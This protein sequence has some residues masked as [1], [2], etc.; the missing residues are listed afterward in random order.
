M[1]IEMQEY[2]QGIMFEQKI[3]TLKKNPLKM[4]RMDRKRE[5]TPIKPPCNDT[6]EIRA[7]T[8]SAKKVPQKK[9]SQEAE[10]SVNN[11]KDS[12]DFSTINE[13]AASDDPFFAP[14]TTDPFGF[15][16]KNNAKKPSVISRNSSY[17][18]VVSAPKDFFSKEQT[19]RR[20]TTDN[21]ATIDSTL[22]TIT[23]STPKKNST[24]NGLE[25]LVKERK[26][27][28]FAVDEDKASTVVESTIQLPADYPDGNY[29]I[30]EI[31]CDETSQGTR[32][33]HPEFDTK[34]I[35]TSETAQDILATSS[36]SRKHAIEVKEFDAFFPGD[37]GAEKSK[38]EKFDEFF[39]P[40]IG[41]DSFF[42]DFAVEK[43]TTPQIAKA[44]TDISSFGGSDYF[45]STNNSLKYGSASTKSL[46]YSVSP[47]HKKKSAAI[48][49]SGRQPLT[50]KNSRTSIGKKMKDNE[51]IVSESVREQE[52]NFQYGEVFARPPSSKKK[53]S[54][55]IS[56][57]NYQPPP[58]DPFEAPPPK[59]STKEN[60]SVKPNR[61][62]YL[63][64]WGMNQNKQQQK[65]QQI[66][67]R[68]DK[69]IRKSVYDQDFDS[70]EDDDGFDDVA[71]WERPAPTSIGRG[72]YASQKSIN[73][74]RVT[75]NSQESYNR[76]SR[77]QYIDDNDDDARSASGFSVGAVSRASGAGSR[78]KPLGM[79]S[80]A[81][82]ASMLFQTQYDIDQNDVENKINAFE[83]ENSRQRRIRTSQGGIPDAVSMD[84][85]YMTTVSSFSEAT[86]AYMQESW[87]KP[88]RDLLNHFTSARA[89]DMDY[90]QR[91][92]VRTSR[93]VEPRQGLYEA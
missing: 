31:S 70:D 80:N 63:D 48:A 93:M 66:L 44:E 85:D 26:F 18:S 40:S 4:R 76:R 67:R 91:P 74:A 83:Q 79:P 42:P 69:L 55:S 24:T 71:H 25:K 45:M 56:S 37:I 6:T 15:E 50:L 20:L 90:R 38:E 11:R 54:S 49:Q 21:L 1:E 52:T 46:A 13:T 9:Q 68:A 12:M 17:N 75:R 58:A 84:D 89:L 43:E 28:Q 41:K 3:T 92:Q 62:E 88:S 2:K 86:S 7:P 39:P 81:I 59:V 36:H 82:V 51:W 19:T 53:R 35:P 30:D 78:S 77:N 14:T 8:S 60:F 27:Y 33:Q 29:S 61:Q 34:I 10:W 22:D 87:R 16:I 57:S 5:L 47:A 65:H 23:N 64:N 32:I 73:R 72:V